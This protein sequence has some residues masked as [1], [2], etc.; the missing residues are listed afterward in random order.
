[1]AFRRTSPCLEAVMRTPEDRALVGAYGSGQVLSDD[2]FR[3][4]AQLTVFPTLISS[5][6]R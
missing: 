5:S 2:Q 4:A 6:R 1:M 3:G